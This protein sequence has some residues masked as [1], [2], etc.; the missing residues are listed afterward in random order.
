MGV[1]LAHR[2][3]YLAFRALEGVLAGLSHRRQIALGSALGGLWYRVDR[4]H[5]RIALENVARAFPEWSP[6][7]VREIVRANFAH[8]GATGAEFLGFSRLSP[9]ELLSRCRFEGMEH[10]EQARSAGK[11]VL[12]LTGHVGNW[13]VV[14]A[15]G[16]AIGLPCYA[17]GRTI[18]NPLV[19]QR[20]NWLR[21]RFGGRVI[22]HRDAVRPILRAL[23]E[24]GVIGFLLDQ[25][26]L[27]REAVPSEFFGRPVATNQGLALLALKTGVPVLPGF[28]ERVGDRHV[29]RIGPPL[30][31]PAGGS[32][33]ERVRR[34]TRLFDAAIEEAVRRRPDQW[35]W[36]HRRWRL[37]REM[38]T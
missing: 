24:G 26:A 7:Q 25:R 1:A 6:R 28:G 36:V 19:D 3:E 35:F 5:R 22:R 12:L 14:G 15:A 16:A 27:R 21:E 2:S 29:L 23:R 30:E 4:R 11:G 31:A 10:L 37:P 32:R 8:L 34:Y 33:E 20:V 17:V 9:G 38:E 13:E 18:R